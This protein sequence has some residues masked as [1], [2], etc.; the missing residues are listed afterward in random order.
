[1]ILKCTFTYFLFN[2]NFNFNFPFE[3]LIFSILFFNNS[4]RALPL[5]SN[6]L[7]KPFVFYDVQGSESSTKG[8]SYHN[9]NEIKAILNLVFLLC[10]TFPDIKVI[11]YKSISKKKIIKI[12]TFYSLEE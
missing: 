10:A 1:M 4:E 3:F 5:H 6:R 2:F 9:Q 7:F 11:S 12:N 8:S